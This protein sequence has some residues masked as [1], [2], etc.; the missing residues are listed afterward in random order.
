MY[1]LFNTSMKFALWAIPWNP[2][3]QKICLDD[4]SMKSYLQRDQIR[5]IS[6]IWATFLRM[7]FSIL[8]HFIKS[9]FELLQFTK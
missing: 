5:Y 6:S 8:G 1:F 2:P 4:L 7:F 3:F 9:K